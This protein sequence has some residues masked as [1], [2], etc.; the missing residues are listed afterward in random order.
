MPVVLC[1]YIGMFYLSIS[2]G[3]ESPGQL[4]EGLGRTGGRGACT[5]KGPGSGVSFAA[6]LGE[7]AEVAI[8]VSS[9]FVVAFPQH[10]EKTVYLIFYK[11]IN[12]FKKLF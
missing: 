5:L 11:N 12:I 2:V 7:L 3:D 10:K 4:G 6:L 8:A 9:V 1:A